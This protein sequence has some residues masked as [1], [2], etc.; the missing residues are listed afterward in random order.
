[1]TET[2][3]QLQ[4]ALTNTFL[5]NLAFLSDYDKELYLRI[6]G[7]SQAINN[8]EYKERYFLEFI[9]EEGEFDIFDEK[10]N[11]YIYD[12]KPN[13]LIKKAKSLDFTSKG[14]FSNLNKKVFTGHKFDLDIDLENPVS[15]T[16]A[17]Q[18]IFNNTSEYVDIYND[19]VET[20]STKKYK[21]FNKFI[22]MGTLL[23]RHILDIHKKFKPDLYFICEENLEIFRLSLFV[24]DYSQFLRQGSGIIFSVMDDESHFDSKITSFLL[25]KAYSNYCV[26]FFTSDYNVSNLFDKVA[27]AFSSN[28]PFAYSYI[29]SLYNLVNNDSK[30]ISKYKRVNIKDIDIELTKKPIIFVGAGPSLSEEIDWL[31]K[32]KDNFIIIAMAASLKKLIN[33]DIIP[34]IITTVDSSEVDVLKQFDFENT[35]EYI[36]DKIV[37]ASSMTS[38]NILENFKQENVFTFDV[39]SSF[40]SET[41][42]Y[43]AY[44][45]GE[46]TL[47]W[48]LSL[49]CKEIYLLGLDLALNQ[50]TGE[51]H[52]SEHALSK[53]LKLDS[54]EFFVEKGGFLNSD[55]ME[56]AG[57]FLEKVYTTRV[58]QLSLKALN[59]ITEVLLKEEQKL[60]NLSKHGAKINKA[61]TLSTDEI[62]LKKIDKDIVLLKEKLDEVTRKSLTEEDMAK[63]KEEEDALH[64]ILTFVTAQKS[65]KIANYDEFKEYVIDLYKFYNKQVSRLVAS[66]RF[67]SIYTD[68]V[69]MY[70]NYCLNDKSIKKDIKKIEKTLTIYEKQ[71]NKMIN[72]YLK[73]SKRVKNNC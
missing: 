29:S 17:V 21:E 3:I 65:R 32:N 13:K 28:N 55:T 19:K 11:S 51:T 70:I 48:L 4:T 73:Y 42:F 59:N 12:R 10:E 7:L 34:D 49:D 25:Y 39:M 56:V 72:D 38:Y 52:I 20:Y 47:S 62:K 41:V 18:M 60:Y 37:L 71:V 54:D 44:S 63:L 45:V 6:D 35:L 14:S 57:N 2:E 8:G 30:L 27:T 5:T 64:E 36:K 1:M 50:D 9:K 33:H 16:D 66:K 69:F 61:I 40:Y 68:T 53:K 43:N 24:L 31:H 22:I 23:G 26:K 67:L 46:M 15:L 58:F